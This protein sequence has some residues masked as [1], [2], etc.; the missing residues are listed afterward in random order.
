MDVRTV[1]PVSSPPT[2]T[3]SAEEQMLHTDTVQEILARLAR[4][5]DERTYPWGNQKPSHSRANYEWD[6]KR[7]WEGHRTLSAVGSY[8]AGKSP[9]GIYD[10]A[11][12]VWEWVA[13]ARLKPKGSNPRGQVCG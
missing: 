3:H 7:M 1:T 10:M 6:G 12:N 13:Q 9:Y 5:T 4:G 11:G 2:Q 8:E